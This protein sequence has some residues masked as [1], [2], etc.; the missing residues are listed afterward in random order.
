[1]KNHEDKY[2]ILIE[3]RITKLET[4][5]GVHETTFSSIDARFTRVESKID[6]NFYWTVSLIVGSI[7]LPY[8]NAYLRYKGIAI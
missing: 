4:L 2:N 7:V 8:L 5:L 1:M 6:R 3:S